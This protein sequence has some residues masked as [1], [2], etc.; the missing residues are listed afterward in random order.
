MLPNLEKL[1]ELQKKT[2]KPAILMLFLNFSSMK[3]CVSDSFNTVC[4]VNDG[5]R[6]EDR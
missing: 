2:L 6:R 1:F 3:N 4:L 5:K